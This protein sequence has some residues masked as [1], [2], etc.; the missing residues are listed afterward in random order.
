M[1]T[2]VL[3]ATSGNFL[4]DRPAERKK[5]QLMEIINVYH[6]ENK[7]KQYFKVV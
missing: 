6:F 3:V 5:G 2:T 4:K 7:L 1:L